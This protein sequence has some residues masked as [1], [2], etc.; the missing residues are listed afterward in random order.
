[1]QYL[2]AYGALIEFGGLAEGDAVIITAA[3]NWRTLS[4]RTAT[5]NP[6]SKW[7]KSS[8]QLDPRVDSHKPARTS[9][10]IAPKVRFP[11]VT[12]LETDVQRLTGGRELVHAINDGII[13]LPSRGM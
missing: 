11:L 10:S 12:F 3:S 6:T 7:G 4:K 1:M 13:V 8:S 5:W 2:T 9:P